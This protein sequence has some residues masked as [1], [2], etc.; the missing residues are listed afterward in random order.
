MRF[1]LI[2]RG[3]QQKIRI[4]ASALLHTTKLSLVTRQSWTHTILTVALL[5]LQDFCSWVIVWMNTIKLSP[6]EKKN[7]LLV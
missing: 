6:L 7:S 3:A 2:W 4:L 5:T 1:V